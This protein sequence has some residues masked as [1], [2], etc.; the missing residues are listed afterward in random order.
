MI[1]TARARHELKTAL[2]FIN[3]PDERVLSALRR[4]RR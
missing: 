4:L 1:T 2:N 3:A